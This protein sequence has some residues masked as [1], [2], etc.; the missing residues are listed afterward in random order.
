MT[1][2]ELVPVLMLALLLSWPLFALAMALASQF[3]SGMPEVR[4]GG[5]RNYWI[6]IP[7]LNEAKV[8]RN[9]VTAALALHSEGAPV[10]VLVVDDASDDET[11]E[12]LRSLDHDRLHVIRREFPEARKGKG[13]ALNAGYRAIR[14]WTA[15]G[16][17]DFT[18]VGIIDG[19]GRAS[20]GTVGDVMDAYFSDPE[21]GAVQSRVRITNRRPLLGL[22]QDIEFSCV[23]NASQSFRDL[24]D[25]VGL[26]GN[27]QFVRL[28]QL[29]RFG[30]S[31]WSSCL[32]EDLELGLRLHLEGVRVR[33]SPQ[34]VIEQ[35]AIVDLR[36]LLRQRARWAQGNLQCAGYLRQLMLSKRVGSLGL[37]DYLVYLVSPWLTV[38]VSIIF[39]VVIA[40]VIGALATGS[41]LGGLA[42]TGAAV[43]AAVAIWV[44]V[45]FFPGVMWGL[46]HRWT[47]GDEPYGRCL[48]AGVCY[49]FFLLIGVFATWRGL[50]RHLAGRDSWAKTERLD[51]M[52]LPAGPLVP[53]PV[54]R[55]AASATGPS[56]GAAPVVR[57]SDSR[58]GPRRGASRKAAHPAAHG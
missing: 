25:T 20:A 44:A 36:R 32:V 22:L 10:R 45:I 29:L 11:P 4:D 56:P 33:Y 27:G 31:P 50:A 49:P 15:A 24:V 12:V 5:G 28:R 2:F 47:I 9:T 42:A 40:V 3:R 8:I 41:S 26:G 7:A 14:T 35:Q 23:A 55:A 34:A 19:D 37:V 13:E 1:G 30:D 46:W 16:E 51:D 38:P 48:V 21:V 53:V 39:L 6:I 52:P 17:V 58:R 43:P 54:L 57:D 18:V